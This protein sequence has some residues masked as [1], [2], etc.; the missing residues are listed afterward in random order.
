MA[1]I[2]YL[3]GAGASAN[4][5]PV[6]NQMPER[7]LDM[8]NKLPELDASKNLNNGIQEVCSEEQLMRIS[9]E[10]RWL[11]EMIGDHDTVDTLAK[12]MYIINDNKSYTRL[13]YALAAYLILE[14]YYNLPDRRYDDFWINLIND[15]TRRLPENMSILSWNYDSQ[16][17]ISFLDYSHCGGDTEDISFELGLSYGEK[18]QGKD[19]TGFSITKLNGTALPE[20]TNPLLSER[21]SLLIT[22]SR[23]VYEKYF[24][25][26]KLW[27]GSLGPLQFAWSLSKKKIGTG[28]ISDDYHAKVQ[29]KIS[30]AEVL[31][32]I[33]YSFPR[34]NNEIDK[35]IIENMPKLRKIYIQD[36][37]SEKIANTLNSICK[38]DFKIEL[39]K[40][41]R[42]FILPPEL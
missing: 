41:T 7:I 21:S 6:V 38:K 23:Y 1:K 4:A 35:M 13:N 29:K 26:N 20:L 17:E 9:N 10:L 2:V 18:Q 32:I 36:P 19:F 37:N 15:R 11:H 22:A 5:L 28:Q 42:Q 8:A 40:D 34:F 16:F 31:V 25:K 39:T 30:D 27:E 14:Q 24:S 3:F 12:K 33:G